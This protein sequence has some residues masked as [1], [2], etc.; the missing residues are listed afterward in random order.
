MDPV[1]TVTWI[2][3]FVI[4]T[5]A[6]TGIVG[7]LGWSAPVALVIVGGAVSFIPA[8]PEVEVQPDL[9]RLRMA[10]LDAERGAVL[11]ARREGRYQEPAIVA[12]LP[13]TDAEETALRAR[14]PRE[15]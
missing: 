2:V 3:L 8:V 12:A 10:M 11:T 7:R 13:A 6:V 4:T 1:G 9:M 5:V 14:F 15:R